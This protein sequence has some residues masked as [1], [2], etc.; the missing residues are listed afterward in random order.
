MGRTLLHTRQSMGYR[1]ILR[2]NH[3]MFSGCCRYIGL[4]VY[5]TTLRNM[6]FGPLC[7]ALCPSISNYVT[8][9]SS[10]RAYGFDPKGNLQFVP[11]QC[12]IYSLRPHTGLL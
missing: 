5:C 12:A 9:M 11:Q 7:C 2:G 8:T 4:S 3:E 6:W 1:R 10:R